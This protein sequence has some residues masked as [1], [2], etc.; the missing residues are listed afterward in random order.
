MKRTFF[1]VLILLLIQTTIFSIKV[2]PQ[3]IILKAGIAKTDI[4]PTESLYMGGYSET[5]RMNPSDGVYGNLYIRALV[6]DDNQNRLVFIESDIVGYPE[7]DYH[8]IRKQV[9]DETGIQLNNI[10]LGAVHNHAAPSPGGKNKSTEWY[11]QFNNKVV[12]TVKEAIQNLEPVRIGGGTGHSKIA[13]NRRKKMQDTFS[14]TTFDENNSSQLYGKYKTDNPQKIR[15][16]EGVIRLGANPGGSIDDEIGIL[17]IDNIHGEPKAVFINYACHGTS[18]GARN[19]KISPEWNGHMLEYIE[20]NIPD[21][22]G[23]F[24]QGAAGDINPRFVGGLDG[25]KDNLEK[26]A[27]LGY[28]I[29]KEV[30]RVFNTITTTPPLNPRIRLVHQE[31]LCPRKYEALNTDFK[32]TTITVPVTAVRIDDFTWMTFPGELFHEIG[33]KIKKSTHTQYSFFVGYCNGSVGYLPTQKAFSEGGYEPS[34]SRF[35]PV[36]EKILVKEVTKMLI[37]L[38]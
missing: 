22:I 17:R 33:K 26:T 34:S 24:A 20:K 1:A 4:T 25:Y 6:F 35:A 13:M 38:Y 21:V 11:R 10:L 2:F 16:I 29:G 27:E 23:I 28:E 36:A 8:T 14:Y 32:N 37:N 19:N 7:A 30:V 31:I 9:S 15:E 3:E 12:L 18:L 5:C